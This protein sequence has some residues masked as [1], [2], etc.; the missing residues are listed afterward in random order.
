MLKS[1]KLQKSCYRQ[2]LFMEINKNV[3]REALKR[4]NITAGMISEI[5][6]LDANNI[7]SHLQAFWVITWKISLLVKGNFSRLPSKNLSVK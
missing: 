1:A 5:Y 4:L 7:I 3:K 6:T 2:L